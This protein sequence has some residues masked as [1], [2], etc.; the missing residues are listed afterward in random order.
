MLL[1]GCI[2]KHSQQTVAFVFHDTDKEKNQIATLYYNPVK[3]FEQSL[4]AGLGLDH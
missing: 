1:S 4:R 3:D 2:Q